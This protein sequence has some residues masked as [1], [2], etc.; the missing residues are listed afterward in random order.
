MNEERWRTDKERSRNRY[1][2]VTK[3]PRPCF[4]FFFLLLLT[5][6]S[7]N[8][9]ISD[10]GPFSSAPSRLFIGNEGW[11]LHSRS[12]RWAGYFSPKLPS[13]P[14]RWKMPQ[15]WPFCPPFEYFAHFLLKCHKTLRIVWQLVLSSLIRKA[16]IQMLANNHPRSK[17]GYDCDQN[18]VMY[19]RSFGLKSSNHVY[20]PHRE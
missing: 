9:S 13:G 3:A 8:L 11:R 5:N 6:F 1:G 15:K 17:L 12:P 14:S 4:F 16:R 18:E 10:V 7:E 19:I 20:T 2:N